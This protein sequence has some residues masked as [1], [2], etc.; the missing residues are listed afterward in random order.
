M[1][2]NKYKWDYS[3]FKHVPNGH[4]T[5]I[6]N[7]RHFLDEL[8]SKLD[9]KVESW[10][11]QTTTTIIENGGSGLLAKYNGSLTSLLT[12]VYPEYLPMVVSDF[13]QLLLIIHVHC[14]NI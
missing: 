14:V 9:I 6:S 2:S 8:A 11:K 12:A 7:Q 5:N 10:S 13:V 3:K 4:W 1:I